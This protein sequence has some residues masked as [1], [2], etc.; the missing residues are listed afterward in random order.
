[1][2]VNDAVLVGSPGAAEP[3]IN[4]PLRELRLR[5]AFSSK[6]SVS[7]GAAGAGEV[8]SMSLSSELTRECVLPERV[9]AARDAVVSAGLMAR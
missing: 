9:M 2:V 3:T 8:V 6:L 1:V 4:E 5:C 7:S